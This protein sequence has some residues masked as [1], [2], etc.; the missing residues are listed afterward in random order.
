MYLIL[1]TLLPNFDKLNLG[2]FLY[3]FSTKLSKINKSAGK[4]KNILNKL[5]STPFANTMPKSFPIVK[6]INT[7]ASKPTMVVI[8]LLEIAA[9]E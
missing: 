1:Y 6:L 3:V 2:D 8:E 5:S 7:K 4:Q 9:N